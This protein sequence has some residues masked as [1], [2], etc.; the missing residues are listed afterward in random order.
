MCARAH[1]LVSSRPRAGTQHPAACCFCLCLSFSKPTDTQASEWTSPQSEDSPG[2]LDLAFFERHVGLR[3][4]FHPTLLGH[5]CF[6]K[7]GL[8][9]RG[10]TPLVLCGDVPTCHHPQREAGDSQS[11]VNPLL[12]WFS[13]Y[14]SK[15]NISPCHGALLLSLH[16]Y[17]GFLVPGWISGD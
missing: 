3:T 8:L 6:T 13:F 14:G 17:L 5:R 2:S 15:R 9:C 7:Q 11:P 16:F 1:S 4:E 10:N 12:S